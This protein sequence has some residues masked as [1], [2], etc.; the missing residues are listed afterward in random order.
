MYF[1]T[2]PTYRDPHYRVAGNGYWKETVGRDIPIGSEEDPIGYQKTLVYYEFK[3]NYYDP[4]GDI[5]LNLCNQYKY[6]GNY[7]EEDV[8]KTSWIMHEC[9]IND[10]RSLPRTQWEAYLMQKNKWFLCKVYK[11]ETEYKN[12]DE[13]DRNVYSTNRKSG[14]N[15]LPRS[16]FLHSPQD[17]SG[18]NNNRFRSADEHSS[19]GFITL[20]RSNTLLHSRQD[21]S[22]SNYNRFCPTDEELVTLYLKN[23]VLDQPLPTN[24]FI[25]DD[26]HVLGPQYLSAIFQKQE[27]KIMYF[28]TWPSYIGNC[29][30]RVAGNGYWKDTEGDDI[31]IGTKENPIGYKKTLIYYQF[32]GNYSGEGARMPPFYQFQ[33]NYNHSKDAKKTSWIMHEYRINDQHNL[34]LACTQNEAYLI[35]NNKWLLCKIY[36]QEVEIENRDELDGKVCSINADM[37]TDDTGAVSIQKPSTSNKRREIECDCCAVLCFMCKKLRLGCAGEEEDVAK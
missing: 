15:E 25:I 7:S 14:T 9:R 32:E 27:E 3:R 35:K 1:F 18:N 36:N 2:R 24:N 21:L 28:F 10:K 13:L 6:H 20:P 29:R 16:N 11:Q 33:G 5:M 37:D 31:K 22:G 23:L 17:R 19:K 12:K 30:S 4:N 34:P 8:I 26:V